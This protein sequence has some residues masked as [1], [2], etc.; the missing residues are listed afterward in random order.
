MIKEITSCQIC[1]FCVV[2]YLRK[3]LVN[4]RLIQKLVHRCLYYDSCD[5]Q[6]M[7]LLINE[8]SL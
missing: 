2:G 8:H 1:H 5:V 7:I 6:I 3:T 4:R